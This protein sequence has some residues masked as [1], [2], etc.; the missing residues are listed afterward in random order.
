MTDKRLSDALKVMETPNPQPE[1]EPN[2]HKLA[3]RLA[4]G[5]VGAAALLA[6]G[7]GV[8][9]NQQADTDKNKDSDKTDTI[10]E[11]YE[12][13]FK[14]VAKDKV[15]QV[16]TADKAVQKLVDDELNGKKDAKD[17]NL[18]AAETAIAGIKGDD[19]DL[20]TIRDAYSNIVTVVKS[21]TVE[22]LK[23]MRTSIANMSDSNISRH[24]NTTFETGMIKHVSEVT[25]QSVKTVTSESKPLTAQ[26]VK[27]KE[28]DIK[29]QQDE[30]AK[31][32]KADADAKAKA[33]ADAKA[34]AEAKA[35]ADAAEAQRQAEAAAQAAQPSTQPAYT[36]APSQSYT[37]PAQGGG[38]YTPPAQGYT[39]P[40]Q[41]YTPSQGGGSTYTPPTQ[42]ARP[43]QPAQP[44]K[45]SGGVSNS[46][47][48][49]DSPN[50]ADMEWG[51]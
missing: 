38:G 49:W 28:A 50:N 43:T 31:K 19:T 25:H 40:A 32:A 48:G 37:P 17:E 47:G 39:P 44:S 36:E 9:S 12:N 24:L 13:I 30:A 46:P 23:N 20:K 35:A 14:T 7:A 15:A 8:V 22:N 3:K 42:P 18:K 41:G 5:A 34:A 6:V 51:H 21:P 33:D 10:K 4:F 27:A 29:K 1:K 26:Q 45:P 16:E 2:D 11:K